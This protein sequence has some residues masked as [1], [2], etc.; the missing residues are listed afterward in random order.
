MSCPTRKPTLWT[1]CKVSIRISLSML[2]RLTRTDV[3]CLLW[4]LCFRS[5]ITLYLYLP[6]ECF[7]LACAGWSG[8]IYYAESIMLFFSWDGSYVVESL[9]INHNNS[10]YEE[11]IILGLIN[12]VTA[13]NALKF[14]KKKQLKIFSVHQAFK[15]RSTKWKYLFCALYEMKLK[16]R[17]LKKNKVFWNIQ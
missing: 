7:G 10:I 6:T 1:L 13:V 16:V 9:Q 8:S 14:R 15:F 17:N 3:F 11:Q 12:K 5:H 2:R 4:I